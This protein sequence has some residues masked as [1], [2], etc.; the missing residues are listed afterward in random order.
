MLGE[1][2]HILMTY[3]ISTGKWA[4]LPLYRAWGF[5]MTATNNQLVLVGGIEHGGNR[6]EVLGVWDAYNKQ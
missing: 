2:N 6:I 3:D 5:A 4:T 1:D